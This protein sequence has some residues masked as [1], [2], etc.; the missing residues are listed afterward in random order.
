MTSLRF[1]L[2]LNAASCLGFGTLFVLRSGPVAAF[3]GTM[4]PAVLFAVGA[5][6]FANGAHLLLASFRR[7]T[8]RFE[9]VWFSLGDMAWWLA[10]LGLLAT[11]VWITT[12]AGRAAAVLVAVAVAG[13]GVAQLWGLG[14]GRTGLTPRGHWSRI[15]GSW[16]AMKPWVRAWLF[17]LNAVFIASMLV[18]P[19][20][21][22]GMVLAAWAASG[23]L[24]L[25]FAAFQGGLTR[26]AG[27]AHLVPWTPLLAWLV[28]WII[29]GDAPSAA[30][31]WAAVLA[32]LTAVC[33]ALDILDAW[34]WWRG[35]RDILS[36][37]A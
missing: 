27:L 23:P 35:E 24:L 31:A 30:L 19:G 11:G 25:G 28:W 8:F 21:A 6:L 22:G 36:R 7:H 33:L 29:R 17:A 16:L 13:L 5:V 12:P 20:A 9:I 32:V 18:L 2:R 34:R 1:V 37:T 15:A 4:P 26:A 3:L 10:S 14:R